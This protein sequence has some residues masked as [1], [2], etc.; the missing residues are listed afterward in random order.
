MS[1]KNVKLIVCSLMILMA[2]VLPMPAF[3]RTKAVF[4]KKIVSQHAEDNRPGNYTKTSEN[5]KLDWNEDGKNDSLTV[6]R[7]QEILTSGEDNA[8]RN[9]DFRPKLVP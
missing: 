4:K 2:A 8:L 9:L 3:A 6:W 5:K 1:I 7:T